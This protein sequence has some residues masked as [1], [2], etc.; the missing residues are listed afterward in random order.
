MMLSD[1]HRPF[2]QEGSE[3]S[4]YMDMDGV[5]MIMGRLAEYA[6]TESF[7]VNKVNLNTFMK[8]TAAY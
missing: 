1:S 2:N 6:N 7:W 4:P 3:C 8:V 5:H